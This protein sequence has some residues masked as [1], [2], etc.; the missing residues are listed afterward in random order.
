[1]KCMLTAEFDVTRLFNLLLLIAHFHD[2]R[3]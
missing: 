2:A 3:D 1:M